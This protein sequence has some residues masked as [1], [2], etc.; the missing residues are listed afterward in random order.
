M[1]RL[2][3][4]CIEQLGSYG[5]QEVFLDGMRG[6]DQGFEDLGKLTVGYYRDSH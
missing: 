4:T 3:G 1:I 5:M 2:L 6:G